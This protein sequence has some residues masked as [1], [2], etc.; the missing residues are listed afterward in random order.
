MLHVLLAGVIGQT[1]GKGGCGLILL[2]M[3]AA[4][5]VELCHFGIVYDKCCRA[6]SIV[7]STRVIADIEVRGILADFIRSANS[8]TL[9]ENGLRCLCDF[10][11]GVPAPKAWAE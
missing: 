6:A 7:T 1:G 9:N 2:T 11:V 8:K 5:D 4:Q 10:H 3:I